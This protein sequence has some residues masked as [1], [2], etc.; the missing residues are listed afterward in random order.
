LRGTA[1]FDGRELTSAAS[2]AVR[3]GEPPL[4]RVWLAT[5]IPT[6]FKV[7][8][9]FQIPYA[10]RG[11]IFTRHY[12]LDRGG[13][14]GPIEVALAEKQARHLQGVT[15]DTV[16]VPAG[17]TEF[18]FAAVLPPWLELGRTSRSV[19]CASA[20]ID[21]GRGKRHRVSFTSTHQ[22]EQVSL[23]ASPGPLGIEIEP[24]NLA[25]DTG[26]SVPAIVHID[27]DGMLTTGSVRVELVVPPHMHGVSAEPVVVPA[28]ENA[29]RLELRFEAGAGPFNMPLTVRA[30]HGS[31]NRGELWVA[32]SP[33]E[34]STP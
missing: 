16:L 22:N 20:W 1:T 19:V 27:R 6:P 31:G 32:E 25:A 11:T 9:F 23:I 21:D 14:D 34:I 13:Y 28:K 17:A 12:V 3:R 33:L 30:T 10:P 5:S 7:V 15:G 18:D 26:Q 29:G 2:L 4:D 8:G 24:A